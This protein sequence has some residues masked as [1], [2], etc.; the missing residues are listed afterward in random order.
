MVPEIKLTDDAVFYGNNRIGRT[1]VEMSTGN[2][3]LCMWKPL[4][5]IKDSYALSVGVFD[6][7]DDDIDYFYVTDND[8][9]D[10]YKFRR[11]DYE[12]SPLFHFNS[13]RQ[14]VLPRTENIGHWPESEDQVFV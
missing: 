9:G 11:E 8:N 1:G 3:V 12:S 14:F 10:V 4:F 5:R 13:Q 2:I 7:I 6:Q